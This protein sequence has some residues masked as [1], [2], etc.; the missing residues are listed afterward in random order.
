MFFFHGEKEQ[1]FNHMMNEI[2]P[3]AVF[4]NEDYTAYSKQRDKLLEE[5]CDRNNAKFYSYS[6]I[7]LIQIGK[8]L[9]G[10]NKCYQKF[11]P[12]YN[13]CLKF[14][15]PE[16]E[17]NDFSNYKSAS[18]KIAGEY[19][20]E[21][22]DKFYENNE[23]IEVRGGREEGLKILERIK[24]WKDYQN[25]RDYPANPTTKLSAYNKF[26]CVSCR[27]VYHSVLKEFGAEH[28]IIRQMYWRDFYYIVANYNPHVF[29][30]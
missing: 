17:H 24:N 25:Q 7:M 11:T 5:I 26:G 21:D 4:V 20:Y 13:A 12:F 22:I 6:D 15:V 23:R 2:K 3:D 27:E 29:G 8:V 10:P 16:P 1:I 14:P 19:K 9:I 28:G 18:E 30:K